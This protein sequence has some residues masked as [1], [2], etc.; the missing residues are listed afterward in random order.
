[1]P[2]CFSALFSWSVRRWV[3][4]AVAAI[5]TFLVVGLPTAVIENPV[6][7]RSVEVTTW[8]MPV[9]VITSVLSGL[10]VAT[11]FRN[12]S[13]TSEEKSLKIGG[14]GAVLSYLA[15]GCPVC[16]K[17]VLIALGSTG[18]IKYF[19]PVQP[20]LA[21]L[22]VILLAFAVQQ[23]LAKESSCQISFPKEL[24][25]DKSSKMESK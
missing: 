21:W 17:L 23:R 8:S 1:M 19:A 11:Y 7:G 22:G 3:V 12:D 25:Q 10:L 24:D 18:A 13:I 14:I 2:N 9:L 6:F 16:N 5:I 20:F 15:V 4:A